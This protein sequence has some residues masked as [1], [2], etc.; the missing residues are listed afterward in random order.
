[1]C[2]TPYRSTPL[3]LLAL[4]GVGLLVISLSIEP[5]KRSCRCVYV[6]LGGEGVNRTGETQTGPYGMLSTQQQKQQKRQRQRQQ[7]WTPKNLFLLLVF[8]LK[9]KRYGLGQNTLHSPRHTARSTLA[10]QPECI[11]AYAVLSST[12]DHSQHLTLHRKRKSIARRRICLGHINLEDPRSRTLL[13]TV[14]AHHFQSG[15]GA[16][17]SL[18]SL[19]VTPS[20]DGSSWQSAQQMSQQRGFHPTLRLCLLQQSCRGIIS[21]LF[22]PNIPLRGHE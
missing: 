21:Y 18:L 17:F 1:M 3:C 4:L 9:N 22:A 13:I 11:S 15:L 19:A 5:T 20:L 14:P 6:T 12:M 2:T 10:C 8:H 7:L 16:T